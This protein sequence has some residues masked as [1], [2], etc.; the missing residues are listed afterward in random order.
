MPKLDDSDMSCRVRDFVADTIEAIMCT[1]SILEGSRGL[2]DA[3][4]VI[5]GVHDGKVITTGM[6][7][8]GHAAQKSASSLSSLGIPSV[9]LHPGEAAH[10]DV[11]VVRDGDVLL[12][13][14]TSGKT[15]E[16]METIQFARKLGIKQVISVTSHKDSAIRDVSDIVV[17]MGPVREAG[18]LGIAPT[19]SIVVMLVISDLIAVMAA[20][21]R[22]FKMPDY[23]LRHH[24]GYL[25]MKSRGEAQDA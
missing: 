5:A 18:Y 7:K 25:G 16:V 6:G 8:A 10:G 24:G 3:V 9:F 2:M 4:E 21:A 20:E 23:A 17:D 19:T 22:G 12:A 13:F 15:R 11:G 14:S 1:G